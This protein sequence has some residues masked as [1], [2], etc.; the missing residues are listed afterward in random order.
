MILGDLEADFHFKMAKKHF[1]VKFSANENLSTFARLCI[2]SHGNPCC[3]DPP[4]VKADASL[5][6]E[7]KACLNI[8]WPKKGKHKYVL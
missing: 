1:F 2:L 3:H 5:S 6:T 8:N 7:D 4:K